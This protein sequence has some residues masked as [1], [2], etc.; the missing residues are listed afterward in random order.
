MR[1]EL[2][3]MMSEHLQSKKIEWEK[4]I[5]EIEV[6]VENRVRKEYEERVME[7]QRKSED[8]IR[9]YRQELAKFPPGG[10]FGVT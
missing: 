3:E 7:V 10:G 1:G 5:E 9:Y 6:E 8:I 4:K 2:N